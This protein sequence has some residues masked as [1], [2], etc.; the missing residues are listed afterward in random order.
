MNKDIY[1]EKKIQAFLHDPP[2][3]FLSIATHVDLSKEL[4]EMIKGY[5][6]DE[7]VHQVSDMIASFR[8]DKR[9]HS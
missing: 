3:K 7:N 8:N 9:I 6:L 1:W 5:T 2:H 4:L